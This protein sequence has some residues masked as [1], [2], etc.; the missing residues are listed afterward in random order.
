MVFFS[1]KQGTLSLTITTSSNISN[2]TGSLQSLQSSRSSQIVPQRPLYSFVLLFI[3]LEGPLG[4]F[5]RGYINSLQDIYGVIMPNGQGTSIFS[6]VLLLHSGS[7]WLLVSC[8]FLPHVRLLCSIMSFSSLE[9][10]PKEL[11]L[12]SRD[13]HKMTHS[14][15]ANKSVL[16]HQVVSGLGSA[17][18]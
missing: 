4:S 18:E 16:F 2:Q 11:W 6:R 15:T 1:L 14:T 5:K 9:W 8:F 3:R 17:P 12:Q 13:L 10:A 7:S